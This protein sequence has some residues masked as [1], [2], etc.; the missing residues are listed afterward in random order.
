MD[1]FQFRFQTFVLLGFMFHKTPK[2]LAKSYYIITSVLMRN[3]GGWVSRAH[4]LD[5]P[6][7]SVGFPYHI[8]KESLRLHSALFE[9]IA[10]RP[11]FSLAEWDRFASSF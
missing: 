10:P 2:P 6:P 1:R 7:H 11:E 8:S 9:C 4:L 5:P 3:G